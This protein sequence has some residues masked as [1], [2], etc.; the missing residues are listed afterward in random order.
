MP[1]IVIT[2]HISTFLP[3]ACLASVCGCT[4][5]PQTPSAW[6]NATGAEQFERLWWQEVKAK[7]WQEVE[8]HLAAT[9]VSS[10]PAGRFDRAA[11]LQHLQKLDISDYSIGDFNVVPN[12]ADMVVTYNM[13]LR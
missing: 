7:N 3:L 4:I 5:W 2:P 9:Y 12:G 11:A 10:T 1:A 8:G 13:T 6:S